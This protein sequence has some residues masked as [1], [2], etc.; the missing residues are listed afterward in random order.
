MFKNYFK[1]A[2]RNLLRNK[3]M[4]FINIFG[5]AIGMTCCLLIMLFVQDETSYDKQHKDSSRVYRIVK[6]FVNDDG[7]KL[8]D[9]TTPPA[10]APAMQNEIPEI[11]KVTRVFPSWGYKNLVQAGEKK[12][13]EERFYRVDSS[14]FEVFTFPL[15][16]GDVKSVFKELNSVVITESIS[17]KYFG[18]DDP[19]G[20][21]LKTDMGDLAVTGVLRD[22]PENNHFH[23]D[24][25]VSIRKLRGNTDLTWGWYNFLYLC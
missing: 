22:V 17:K 5:L 6:D 11:E 20:K 15:V 19:M 7:S 25:L 16:R 10:L 3:G 2:L 4:A 21:I 8:P 23:F 9:A 12:F 14:F 13:L 24:F 18:D 1:T